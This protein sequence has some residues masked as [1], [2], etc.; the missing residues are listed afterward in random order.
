MTRANLHQF[1][2]G[3]SLAL[4]AVGAPAAETF[5]DAMQKSLLDYSTRPM[6]N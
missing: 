3:L 2:A 6:R 4:L 5:D 1:V